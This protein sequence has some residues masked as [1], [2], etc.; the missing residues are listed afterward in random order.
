MIVV[1]TS[2]ALP[3]SANPAFASFVDFSTNASAST[4]FC[5]AEIALYTLSAISAAL[6]PV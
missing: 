3:A 5:P 6:I 4:V 1:N 2:K